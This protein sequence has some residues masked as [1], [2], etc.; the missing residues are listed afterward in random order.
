VATV[1]LRWIRDIVWPNGTLLT[2]AASTDTDE[3]MRAMR[4]SNRTKLAA[5]IPSSLDSY[6]GSHKV[7]IIL[8]VV[9][10][11]LENARLK[12]R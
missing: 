8:L 4:D 5:M 12:V 6:I 2:V 7:E 3:S 9:C 10:A 11:N 1:T